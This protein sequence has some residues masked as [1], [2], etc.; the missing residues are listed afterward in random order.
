MSLDGSGLLIA[1]RTVPSRLVFDTVKYREGQIMKAVIAASEPSIVSVAVR[2]PTSSG[3]RIL[4]SIISRRTN[5]SCSQIRPVAIP[6][7]KDP[8]GKICT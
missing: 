2:H 5:T 1:G 3:K 6:Q 7:T 8:N 4:Y